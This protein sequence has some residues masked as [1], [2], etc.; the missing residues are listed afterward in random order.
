VEYINQKLMCCVITLFINV[1][2]FVY[3]S[4]NLG[5][6]RLP[7]SRFF[8]SYRILCLSSESVD[9]TITNDNFNNGLGI[10]YKLGLL[11]FRPKHSSTLLGLT[12]SIPLIVMTN[13]NPTETVCRNQSVLFWAWWCCLL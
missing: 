1:S 11:S 3:I 9:T 6:L 8:L 2:P 7:Y 5:I 13:N 4:L 12:R 10:V